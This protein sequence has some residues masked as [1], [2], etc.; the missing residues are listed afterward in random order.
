MRN[1]KPSQRR[2]G[3]SLVELL[4]VIV[5]IGIMASIAIPAISGVYERSVNA[6]SRRNAQNISALYAALRAAGATV[7]NP[8]AA[9]IAAAI[10]NEAT[11][12][13]SGLAG[14]IF[15]GSKFYVPMV[16]A[17]RD[18]AAAKLVYVAGSDSLSVLP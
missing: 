18:L 14:T 6:K 10:S 9:T 5:V 8:D 17:E 16:D 3:F 12:G 13:I 15:A 4:V 7:V 1:L 11:N 2:G